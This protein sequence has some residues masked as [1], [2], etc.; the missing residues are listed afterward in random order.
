MSSGFYGVDISILF[1]VSSE[2]ALPFRVAFNNQ[3][4]LNCNYCKKKPIHLQ[5]TN[6]VGPSEEQTRAELWTRC[7]KWA[8][9]LVASLSGKILGL[10]A[11]DFKIR[12]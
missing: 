2:L 8:M 5:Q 1:Y 9:Q 3:G 11:A 7:E 4:N 10:D 12:S 6:G